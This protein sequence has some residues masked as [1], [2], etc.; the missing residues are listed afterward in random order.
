MPNGHGGARPGSGPKPRSQ[1]FARP[2]AAAEKRV[3]DWLPH[4]IETMKSLADGGTLRTEE[5]WVS[6]GSV[7]VEG[8]LVDEK[9]GRARR[10]KVPAFPD[11]P[12]DAMVLVER[13]TI[14]LAPDARA[15]EYLI[16]RIMGRPVQKEEL[17]GPDGTAIA[18]DFR[19]AIV[20]IYGN[21]PDG[22]S[23]DP[24]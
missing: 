19:G 20:K 18:L 2:I 6:A 5:K 1:R 11:L 10:V 16:D 9:T 21:A 24:D 14:T 13:R 22:D 3:A 4:L 17:S 12:P 15:N 8:I 23:S 7:T